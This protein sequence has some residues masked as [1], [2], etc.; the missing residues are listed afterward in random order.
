[1]TLN[2]TNYSNNNSNFNALEE[3]M[4]M[5]IEEFLELVHKRR[6]CRRFKPDPIPDEWV[7]KILEAGRWAM[8]GSNAQPWEFIVVKDQDT[9]DRM[10]EKWL[11]V[12][13]EYYAP[14]ERTRK[15]EFG[16][17]MPTIPMTETG[18]QYAPVLIVCLGDRRT[19]QG[20]IL[21]VN[22]IGAEGGKGTDATFLKNMASAAQIIH[23]A[24]EALEI[25]SQHVSVNGMWEYYLREILEVPIPLEIHCVVP[26][27]YP[28]Y[29]FAPLYRRELEE[30]VHYEKYD[31]KK[32]RTT[33]D[34]N[35]F[36]KEKVVGHVRKQTS[37][38]IKN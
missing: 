1:M 9:K 13:K 7:E 18:W 15:L 37:A 33:E 2:C 17:T 19:V 30:F 36:L 29:E 21:A 22:F 28:D 25:A 8:S 34:V 20:T 38:I 3:I 11:K 35:R 5:S 14:I 23:L 26:L 27:G 32:Y 6:S 12:R 16:H 10:A 31:M 4:N 24:A